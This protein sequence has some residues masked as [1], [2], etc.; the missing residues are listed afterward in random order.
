MINDVMIT[1]ETPVSFLTVRQLTEILERT[2]KAEPSEMVKPG[3]KA[4]VHGLKGIRDL[5]QVSHATAQ[6]YADSFLKPAVAK[7]GRKLLIDVSKAIELF[8]QEKGR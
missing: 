2:I 6:R 4:Y 3:E 1:P 7:R 8:N 5:F